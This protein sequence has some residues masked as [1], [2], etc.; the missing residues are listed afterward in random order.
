MKVITFLQS[1]SSSYGSE[2]HVS[3][4]TFSINFSKFKQSRMV[5]RG[6]SSTTR[7]TFIQEGFSS[8]LV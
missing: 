8:N 2:I 4:A 1:L 5:I 3:M 6:I 7:L